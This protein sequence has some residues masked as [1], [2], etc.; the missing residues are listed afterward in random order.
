MNRVVNLTGEPIFITVGGRELLF[1]PSNGD[2]R[3]PKGLKGKWAMKLV[4]VPHPHSSKSK[5]SFL[6]DPA[7]ENHVVRR[8]MPVK[9]GEK[10]SAPWL[11]VDDETARALF[12]GKKLQ[13]HANKGPVNDKGEQLHGLMKMSALEGAVAAAIDDQAQELERVQKER[14]ALKNELLVLQAAKAKA[15]GEAAAGKTGKAK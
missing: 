14:E 9:T 15:L 2:W 4:R 12:Q 11:D 10:V 13:D 7:R 8:R 5:E 1:P 6:V 3:N